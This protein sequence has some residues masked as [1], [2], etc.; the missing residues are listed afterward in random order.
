M[1]GSFIPTTGRATWDEWPDM[2]D[3]GVTCAWKDVIV[4]AGMRAALET[5]M[6]NN[7]KTWLILIML[8]SA[9][10]CA[11]DDDTID[12]SEGDTKS[13]GNGSTDIVLTD[14]SPSRTVLF[15]CSEWTSCEITVQ[16]NI[17]NVESFRPY[18]EAEFEASPGATIAQLLVGEMFIEGRGTNGKNETNSTTRELVLTARQDDGSIRFEATTVFTEG[19]T[20][21]EWPLGPNQEN[22]VIFTLSEDIDR[23]ELGVTASWK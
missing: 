18:F 11:A 2:W 6:R 23:L 17:L 14:D 7:S 15:A 22:T 10:G 19:E 20:E 12:L 13:D 21:A 9:V 5:G 3:K 4:L 1:P 16:A 8:A